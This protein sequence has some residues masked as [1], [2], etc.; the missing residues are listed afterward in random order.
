MQQDLVS[1]IM[2]TFNSTEFVGDSIESILN[3]TYSNFELL[4][5]DDNSTDEATKQVLKDYVKRDSRI[6]I[7]FLDKN[8]G[9]GYARNN[10]IKEAC[11]RF[12]AF[13]DSDDRWFPEKLE[14][15]V[16]FILER[17]CCLIFSSYLVCDENN[18]NCGI[19]VAPPKVTLE[20]MK[21]DNKIGC[22]T[23]MY[24]TSIYGKFY[25]P[26]LR[27]RQDWALFLSILKKCKVAY[28]IKEPLAYYRITPKSVSRKKIA[29]LK[30]NAMVYRTVFGY[31][32]LQ[33][34]GYLYLIFLPSHIM[35]LINNKIVNMKHRYMEDDV[36]N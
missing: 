26:T 6:R 33:A 32:K 20:S 31:T 22:L 3:Q 14:R 35:K 12:I 13:C 30:Y 15:Q 21:H 10:S 7:F 8:M 19:V 11:G 29:L 5:T 1:I 28:S 24:D 18:K 9:P 34:Y 27:K 36:N 17:K 23:A 2:P 16:K 25:M 4:I